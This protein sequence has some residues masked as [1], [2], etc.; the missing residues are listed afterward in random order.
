MPSFLVKHESTEYTF[1]QS[2]KRN[3]I[4]LGCGARWKSNKQ[5]KWKMLHLNPV[6]E[7]IYNLTDSWSRGS[8]WWWLCSILDTPPQN[9]NLR[10]RAIAVQ[11][12][13]HFMLDFP[14]MRNACAISFLPDLEKPRVARNAAGKAA[15]IGLREQSVS[16]TLAVRPL[17]LLLGRSSSKRIY[18]CA[19]GSMQCCIL[20][21]QPTGW[22]QLFSHA[23]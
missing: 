19:Y 6:A 14:K 3:V 18:L 7:W 1:S 17:L 12:C 23:I 16:N 5:L 21:T 15:G 4:I 22:Q 9:T 13:R 11:A 10:A 8:I 2:S 20:P